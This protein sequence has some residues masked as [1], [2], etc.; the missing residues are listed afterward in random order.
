MGDKW[1]IESPLHTNH[2]LQLFCPL[3]EREH[4]NA[5]KEN[6]YLEI[7]KPSTGEEKR[8]NIKYNG[9]K[10]RKLNKIA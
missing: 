8:T 4:H 3:L 9:E 1:G 6:Q 7:V 10:K 2:E 5:C